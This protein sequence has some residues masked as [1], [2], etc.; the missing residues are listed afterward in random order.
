MV[1]FAMARVSKK[2]YIKLVE[3]AKREQAEKDAREGAEPAA[4]EEEVAANPLDSIEPPFLMEFLASA[5]YLI[6]TTF[7]FNYFL[8]LVA[9]GFVIQSLAEHLPDVFS[10]ATVLQPENP[11]Q[12]LVVNYLGLILNAFATAR[13]F[14]TQGF[15]TFNAAVYGVLVPN[16][17]AFVYLRS[18]PTWW[19]TA[20]ATN[21]FALDTT[22]D[23]VETV[24]GE[25]DETKPP[26]LL[27]VIRLG[28]AA[29][30]L[31][32]TVGLLDV[33]AHFHPLAMFF[34]AKYFLQYLATPIRVDE[35][36]ESI[37]RA[38]SAALLAPY[39]CQ[40][41]AQMCVALALHHGPAPLAVHVLRSALAGYLAGMVAIQPVYQFAFKKLEP[42]LHR[43]L[44]ACF[45]AV[46]FVGAGVFAVTV[47]ARPVLGPGVDPV[48]WL[49][50]YSTSTPVFVTL[51]RIW[52]GLAVVALTV[53]FAAPPSALNARRKFW[54]VVYTAAAVVPDAVRIAT[55]LD[56]PAPQVAEF[57]NIAL[58]V[59]FAL[60]LLVETVRSTGFPPLG[61]TI[62]KA[63][64]PFQ[65]SRDSCGPLVILYLFLVLGTG[66]PFLVGPRVSAAYLGLLAV[67]LGDT[68]ALVVGKRFGTL[69]WAG[70]GNQKTVAG[71]LGY[72]GAVLAGG[73][74]LKAL[75]QGGVHGGW[76]FVLDAPLFWSAVIGGVVEGCSLVNDNL[77]MPV[78]AL[79]VNVAVSGDV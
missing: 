66:L 33:S 5:K 12:P 11:L 17:V 36:A 3:K 67:G 14:G 19:Y 78:V 31:V 21:F 62:Q 46:V 18:L 45:V 1:F 43:T 65:D 10:V 6:D 28:S 37:T 79:L 74:A 29:L 52:S 2:T 77:F 38:H 35:V 27:F 71:T 61:S 48:E 55:R 68:F 4:G 56:L 69:K 59:V 9:F 50:Q 24:P 7:T 22:S 20:L 13:Q 8:Q 32:Q 25:H 42:G 41:L 73:L 34:L 15:P 39:E 63:F 40:W 44:L 64:A 60:L 51:L 72:I 49:W 75:F 76:Q 57:R 70:H 23:E 26:P 53:A 16:L 58:V 54:H 30:F 47:T